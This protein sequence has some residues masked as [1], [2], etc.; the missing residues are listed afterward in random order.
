M[1]PAALIQLPLL[2]RLY[3]DNNKLSQLPAELGEVKSLKV[4]NVDNNM[5]VSL[6]GISYNTTAHTMHYIDNLCSYFCSGIYFIL[7]TIISLSQKSI[8]LEQLN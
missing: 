4:L 3:L 5:L 8:I 6:P 2:E 7:I 1:L